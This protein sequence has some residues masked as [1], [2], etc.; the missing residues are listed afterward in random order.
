MKSRDK[1][2]IVFNLITYV[3][4]TIIAVLCCAPFLMIISSSLTTEA[5]IKKFG[6]NIF[7]R[8]FSVAAYT[9]IF[10]NIGDVLR[11]Y[12]VTTFVTV[13]GTVLSLFIITMTAFVL[14]IKRFTWANKFSFFFYFTT[15]F[16]GGLVPWYVL[17]VRY[18]NFKN[19][20][21]VALILPYL[22]NVFYL[23]IMKTFIRNNVHDAIIESGI[24]DGAGYFTI[25]IRLVYPLMKPALATIGLFIALSYWNDFFLSML[26]IKDSNFNQLQYYLYRMINMREAL[27]RITVT[28]NISI[29]DL[30]KESMKMA[31]TVI[32]TGPI[33]LL[34]PFVQKY[35]VKGLTIGSVKG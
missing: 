30:P 35:F 18:L 26:F 12:N 34:Y 15:L 23:I 33:L 24:M 6:Y 27:T 22:F 28:T 7:P 8:E 16:Q 9:A 21:L 3:Y 10:T 1:S 32:V 11:A 29:A 2:N 31:M 19:M 20:P 13:V 4:V 17:C 14:S 5:S 25:L